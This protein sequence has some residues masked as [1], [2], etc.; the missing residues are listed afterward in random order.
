[1][2]G[3]YMKKNKKRNVNSQPANYI[4]IVIIIALIATGFNL[5]IKE[6]NKIDTKFKIR[7]EVREKQSQK[8]A[9]E[10]AQL[11]L[12]DVYADIGEQ[13]KERNITITNYGKWDGESGNTTASGLK[14]KDFK[15]NEDGFYTHNGYVVL[16]TA[17]TSRLNKK[18]NN[19]YKSH[20]L[21]E[22][23]SFE[24][25]G[26]QYHGKALD[27]CGACYGLSNEQTQRYDIFTT[28][29]VIG[30]KQGVIYE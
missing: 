15:V 8:Y 21:G 28:S 22:I 23:I 6:K 3:D 11:G 29:N 30:K 27:V 24:L 17:N 20:E 5:F 26:K 13:A 10:F 4:P 2:K 14:I 19:G 1:M 12:F 9:F 18:L 7:R 25:N 16:A